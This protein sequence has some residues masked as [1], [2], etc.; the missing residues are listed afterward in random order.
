MEQLI[1]PTLLQ[2]VRSFLY[3]ISLYKTKGDKTDYLEVLLY[4][5]QFQ[6]ASKSALYSDGIRYMPFRVGLQQL[7][8]NQLSHSQK[9]LILGSGI[10]SVLQILQKGYDNQAHFVLVDID[11]VILDLA[12]QLHPPTPP[13]TADYIHQDVVD[14]MNSTTEQFDL[15]CIDVF[16]EQTVPEFICSKD[17][18]LKLKQKLHPKGAW[19]M[20]YIVHDEQKASQ[21]VN[22]IKPIFPDLKIFQKKLNTIIYKDFEVQ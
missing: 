10:G 7:N 20:N 15:I 18:F 1:Q 5:N 4:Q 16:I 9:V 3:P 17:F 2:R 19:I 14:F 12:I 21:F 8:K 6:L 11:R 22:E 13:A